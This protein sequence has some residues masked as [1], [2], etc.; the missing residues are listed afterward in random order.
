MSEADLIRM[1]QGDIDFNSLN[2]EKHVFLDETSLRNV[3]DIELR[4]LGGPTV[5]PLQTG[6]Q[7]TGLSDLRFYLNGVDYTQHLRD[8]LAEQLSSIDPVLVAQGYRSGFRAYSNL[9]ERLQIEVDQRASD[10]EYVD[11][12]LANGDWPTVLRSLGSR[13]DGGWS[14]NAHIFNY[15]YSSIPIRPL[16]LL[17]M[18]KAENDLPDFSSWYQ[19]IEHDQLTLTFSSGPAPTFEEIDAAFWPGGRVSYFISVIARNPLEAR[20]KEL[21]SKVDMLITMTEALRLQYLDPLKRDVEKLQG[22]VE[23]SAAALSSELDA[24]RSLLEELD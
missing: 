4:L 9:A 23:G 3:R 12:V 19:S 21:R 18:L 13:R 1:S 14:G 11:Q 6:Q 5:D 16:S 20:L 2:R 22:E 24:V 8:Q 17:S 15:L 7:F 10:Q